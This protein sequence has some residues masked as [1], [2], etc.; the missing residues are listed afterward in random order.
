MADIL[1]S[2]PVEVVEQ[3]RI[4]GAVLSV[5]FRWVLIFVLTITLSIQLISGY[6][7]E[8]VHSFVLISIYFL[9]NVG[10]WLAIR[11]KYNPVYLGYLSA[12]LDVCMITFHLYYSTIQYDDIALTSAATIFLYPIL[13]VLYTFRLNRSLLIFLVFFSLIMFNINYFNSYFQH[14]E[15][16][17]N[18]LSTSPQ[19]HIFKSIYIFF[20]GFLCVYLQ[21]S[22]SEF[23]LKQITQA[24]EKAKSDL[25]VKIEEQ[26][27]KYAQE[28]I[29]QEKDQNKRLEK[30]VKERTKELTK[31]NTQLINLQKENL[32]SQFD[33]L[34]QQVNPHFLF[35]SLN[36]LTSLIKLEP[37]LA[38]KFSEQLSKVYR[39]I[40]ENKDNELVDLQ[41]EL[42][43]LDAYIFL[44]NIRFVGKLIVNINIPESR[45]RD[46]I[47]P[48]AMQLLIENAIKHNTMSKSE[49]LNID[50]F[51]D[52]NNF[53][54][55]INNL[56]ERPSQL[57]ST[58]VGLKNIQNRYLLL[59]NTEPKF[60]KTETH[61]IA[62]VPLVLE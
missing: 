56:Q 39:Y 54:N 18:Y 46:L 13:F 25:K 17:S 52:E 11:K 26:K 49:P 44:L 30:E 1:K 37:D 57:V 4:K 55:I 21:H 53:L 28:L 60:K 42:N 20:I 32:Q 41:T 58:G 40:L 22:I 31:A 51:I 33:V 5:Y 3:E 14:P 16:Y 7:V 36:V 43:F 15:I 2:L 45:R 23:I 12:I 35:N 61:F 8:S 27:N 9:L 10:L 48:L 29:D 19:S 6:K 59:N 50:V 62:Q 47:I 34:K 38:E 24:D